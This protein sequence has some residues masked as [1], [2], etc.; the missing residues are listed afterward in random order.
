ME[1]DIDVIAAGYPSIDRIIKLNETPVIGKTAIIQ[2]SDNSVTY[3][4][5]CN[6]N[7]AY[8]LS[9]IG[10]KGVPA[11][12]VGSDFKSS[13]FYDFL[14]NGNVSLEGIQV[15]EEDV[16][17][18]TYLIENEEGHHITLF[19][20]GAMS[21]AYDADMKC[22]LI[23]RSKYGLITVGNTEFN[24]IFLMECNTMKVPV[25][26]GMKCDFNAFPIEKL[27]KFLLNST[28]I[29]T[30]EGERREIERVLGYYDI[31]EIFKLG[32]AKCIIVTKGT[33][34]SEIIYW[35]NGE[36]LSEMIGIAK[37]EKI[38]DTSG[39]GD[40]YISGFLYGLINEKNFV[41]CGKIGTVVSSFI[42]E[43]MGCLTNIP[44]EDEIRH[45]YFLTYGE[46]I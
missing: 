34:G 38:V 29:F 1:K 45:R 25:I 19:Y 3:Y 36:I 26:F 14:A 27:E 8:L 11:M 40:G 24:E 32:K 13:G 43:K 31:R 35:E 12:K 18:N 44:S 42:I 33:M 20:P 23:E 5:G 22:S 15:I 4:G 46:E 41:E 10:V 17:S 2:N 21:S 30:N 7:V 28:V 9:Q 39:V 16:T 37:P 6:V